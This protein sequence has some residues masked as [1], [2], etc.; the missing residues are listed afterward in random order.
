M[1][2]FI[3][4]TFLKNSSPGLKY[5]T[6]AFEITAVLPIFFRSTLE[7]YFTVVF[8]ATGMKKG[9]SILPDFVLKIATRAFLSLCDILNEFDIFMK[10]EVSFKSL[11]GY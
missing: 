2:F 5:K 7:I 4:P 8:V 3:P 10:M 1:N 11:I 6:K 9:V